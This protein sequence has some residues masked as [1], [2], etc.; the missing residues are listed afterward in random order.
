MSKDVVDEMFS[1]DDEIVDVLVEFDFVMGED[2][3]LE[4]DVIV[5]EME[6]NIVVLEDMDINMLEEGEYF[7]F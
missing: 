3:G 7:V 6:D 1:V 4:I 5:I 2:F